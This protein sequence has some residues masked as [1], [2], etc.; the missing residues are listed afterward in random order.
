[1]ATK[2]TTEEV[3]LGDIEAR[4]ESIEGR[5]AD[6]ET[7]SGKESKEIVSRLEKVE[8]IAQ[9]LINTIRMG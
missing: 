8:K 4:L 9:D 3:S 6:I 5:V 7:D 1:M 2:K